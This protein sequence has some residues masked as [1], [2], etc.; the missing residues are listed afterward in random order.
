MSVCECEHEN[1][2]NGESH[3]YGVEVP[4]T[5]TVNSS[6]GPFNMC[7]DCVTAHIYVQD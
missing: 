1:H 7:A 4:D 6:A 2:F 5:Q 3:D